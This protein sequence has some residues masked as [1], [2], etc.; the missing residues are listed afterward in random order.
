MFASPPL[1]FL[2]CYARTTRLNKI[3]NLPATI[4]QK[5][6]ATVDRLTS[7]FT[8]GNPLCTMDDHF[9]YQWTYCII[10]TYRKQPS[11]TTMTPDTLRDTF[12]STVSTMIHGTP[13]MAEYMSSYPVLA[14]NLERLCEVSNKLPHRFEPH[15]QCREPR[16]KLLVG[17]IGATCNPCMLVNGGHVLDDEATFGQYLRACDAQYQ[18]IV[19]CLEPPRKRRGPAPERADQPMTKAAKT[20]LGEK[21][22][23]PS[24]F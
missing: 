4:P 5:L 16:C 20:K 8:L 10:R 23:S 12:L 3:A 9:F 14:T 19:L 13:G 15:L 18:A 11:V 22:T 21:E 6:I 17:E 7:V 1:A 2:D 24:C